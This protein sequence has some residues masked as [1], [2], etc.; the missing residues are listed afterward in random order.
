MRIATPPDC[1]DQSNEGAN[2]DVASLDNG[3]GVEALVSFANSRSSQICT[4]HLRQPPMAYIDNISNAYSSIP[5]GYYPGVTTTQGNMPPNLYTMTANAIAP[6]PS[7]ASLPNTCNYAIGPNSGY[8]VDMAAIG[9]TTPVA[10]VAVIGVARTRNVK[11][12]A[13][14]APT[15]S[16]TVTSPFDSLEPASTVFISQT[17]GGISMP[18]TAMNTVTAT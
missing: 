2:L 13:N 14:A 8:G 16:N 4:G 17:H 3:G 5:G 9:G 15:T 18:M 6:V 11:T 1:Y 10:G 12:I 7:P